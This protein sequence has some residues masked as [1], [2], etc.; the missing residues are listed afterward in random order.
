MK[1]TFGLVITFVALTISPATLSGQ[2]VTAVPGKEYSEN[3]DQDMFALGDFLQ[4]LRWDGIGNTLDAFDYSNSGSPPE[5][6]DQ[7]D[8]LANGEDF[9]FQQ[10]RGSL[11]PFVVSF[12]G[13]SNVHY[14]RTN[15]GTGIWATRPQVRTNPRLSDDL[16]AL[17]LWGDVTTPQDGTALIHGDDANYFSIKGDWII[18]NNIPPAISVYRYD[19][20]LDVSSAYF[21]HD[22]IR[23]AVANLL[24]RNPD[25]DID[26]DAM[27]ING[28]DIMFSLE[29]VM[30]AGLDGGEIFTWRR[31]DVSAQYLVHGGRVWDTLNP[32]GAIF[33]VNTENIDAFEGI[34]FVVPEPGGFAVALGLVTLACFRR[35]RPLIRPA[36]TGS[37]DA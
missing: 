24:E 33:G 9:L 21:L 8:A 5:D 36:Q 23:N 25:F 28:D 29:P 35:R 16:D 2:S 22:E 19:P 32:V 15:G 20:M 14:H 26:L 30:Q 3:A 4:N 11:A 17:E 31:G 7:V 1:L 18:P 27:M 13:P 37:G 34:S 10:V 6:P 12:S